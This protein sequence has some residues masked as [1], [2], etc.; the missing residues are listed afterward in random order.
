DAVT[1][2]WRCE[3]RE[4]KAR[5]HVLNG[6][7]IKTIYIHSHEASASKIEADRVITKIKCRA[8]ETVEETSQL[9]NE[10]VVNISEACQ[11]SLP[12]HDALRKLVRRKRNRIHY[13]PANPIN[14]ETLIIPDCYN[15]Y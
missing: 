5:V 13:T 7:I 12:T 9:I 11:G 4:C 10:G 2:F 14:L 3:R 1:Q 15:V 8:A 6:N